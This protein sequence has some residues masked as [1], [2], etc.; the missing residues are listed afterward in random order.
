MLSAR[1]MSQECIHPLLLPRPHP[2]PVIL[3]RV[4]TRLERG[5]FDSKYIIGL[6][7]CE[8]A[9]LINDP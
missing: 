1:T 5:G 2:R 6:C 4:R 8:V 3:L 9:I 7:S